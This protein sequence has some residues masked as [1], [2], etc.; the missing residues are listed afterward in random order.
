MADAYEAM[1]AD[2]PYRA[3]MPEHE[4]R[5]ELERCSGTQFDPSVVEAF[6]L[7]LDGEQDP[8]ATGALETAA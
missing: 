6:L 5:A 1:T 3:G 2:R 7:A 8:E 4:A